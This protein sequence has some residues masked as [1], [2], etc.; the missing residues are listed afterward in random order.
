MPLPRIAII[1]AGIAGLTAAAL[2]GPHAEVVV[3]D[4][5]RGVGG[6]M[7]SRRTD[8]F[9]F[10]HGAQFFTAR[11]AAF[12]HF[13]QPRIDDG[14]IRA[15][16]PR[17]LTLEAGAKPYRRDWFEPHYVGVPS[18]T[19]LPKALAATLTLKLQWELA[20]LER[21]GEHWWL[22]A[23]DG[24]SEG[25]FDWVIATAPAP[26]IVQWF[27]PAFSGMQALQQVHYSPCFA[28]MLGFAELPELRWDAARVK[29][30]PL[31]WIVRGDSRP[32]Q[33]SGQTLLLHSTHAWAREQLEG[34]SDS[35]TN[36]MWQA[37]NAAVGQQLPAPQ[38][39]LLHRWRFAAATHTTESPC[40]LDIANHLGACGD[41][42]VF[43]NT[44]NGGARVEAAFQ[45]AR[46]LANKLLALPVF[47]T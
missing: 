29:S 47:I 5:S 34:D 6:R 20:Q 1:G 32:G 25:P 23:T 12:R 31:D 4:K 35:I 45:S 28:L 17:V 15:W 36:S 21:S 40:E 33:L 24:S 10:D 42:S 11:S 37:L 13:L 14:T 3:I 2:L 27:P 46:A 44:E 41:W 22:H 18:M 43:S 8:A 9:C 38:L 16:T 19:A 39:S 30:S 26:Q 7:A